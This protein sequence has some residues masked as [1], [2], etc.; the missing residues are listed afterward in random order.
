LSEL[1]LQ[2]SLSTTLNTG[3]GV[4]TKGGH[5]ILPV[6]ARD[7]EPHRTTQESMFNFVRM[8]DGGAPRFEGPRSEI[9]VIADLA[10]RV[11]QRVQRTESSHAELPDGLDA[12]RLAGLDWSSMS[13]TE[14]IRAMI[15]AVVP[16]WG[17]VGNM[18][19]GGPEFQID[20]RTFHTPRFATEDGRARFHSGSLPHVA[21][22]SPDE[23]R[24][25][26]IRSEGQFNTVVYE[27]HDLYRGTKRRDIIMIHPDDAASRG[28]NHGDRVTVSGPGGRMPH[29]QIH[30]F[31][32]IRP[33][34]AAMYFP[35]AN[36]LLDHKVD[37]H[38]RTP[39]FKG[40]LVTLS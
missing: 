16:G 32:R 22:A 35:E 28:L 4:A 2:V 26:T 17:A 34:N 20:G 38:S 36:V 27:E 31:D 29:Q 12:S 5:L 23:L 21:N 14:G 15:A 37:Q 18:D 40:A 6:L 7:E 9:D 33:G 3:H 13:D 39:A 25:M 30:L 8:S 11:H 19:A 10:A 24:L 1:D